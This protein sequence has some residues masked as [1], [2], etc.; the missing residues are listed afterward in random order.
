[1]ISRS[2]GVLVASFLSMSELVV[3][4][5]AVRSEPPHER[6]NRVVVRVVA[7]APAVCSSCA[8]PVTATVSGTLTATAAPNAVTVRVGST[9]STASPSAIGN[10]GSCSIP[11]IE[12]G[13][14]FD[15]RKETA[16]QPVDKVSYNHESVDDIADITEFICNALLTSCNADATAQGTCARAQAAAAA[17]APREGIDADA[18]NAVFG[19]QTNFKSVN[20]ISTAGVPITGST[21]NTTS[22]AVPSATTDAHGAGHTAAPSIGNFGSC[23][24]P[25]IE[26]GTG[27][28][29]RKETSFQAVNQTS[30]NQ[31]SALTISTITQSICDALANSCGADATARATCARAQSA[32]NAANPDDGVDADIFNG[33]F[34]ISTNF[35]AVPIVGQ[36]AVTTDV[37][38]PTS[39]TETTLTIASTTATVQTTSTTSPAAATPPA[40]DTP[41][42]AATPPVAATPPAAATT[43][44]N[45]QLFTGNLGGITAPAVVVSGSQFQVEGN[46]IFKSKAQALSRSCNIQKNDC[47]DAANAS[48][49]QGQFTVTACDAQESACNG[50]SGG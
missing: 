26:F 11:Q 4:L 37:A 24:I 46:S 27:F 15:G 10:F 12:F 29:G 50:A 31:A 8:A 23:S 17:A 2:I 47:S 39:S 3:G 9:S 20:A 18:F 28:D 7:R 33:F 32:A 6:L 44:S 5:P 30:Y 45:L 41:P 35:A 16:F 49:N 22:S 34:G 42:A 19:I 21:G 1:M 25:E 14:G 40:A 48:K 38:T 43:A 13:P 36:D